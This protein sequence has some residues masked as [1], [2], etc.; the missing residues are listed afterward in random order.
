MFHSKS[1]TLL[2]LPITRITHRALRA[3]LRAIC[4][5]CLPGRLDSIATLSRRCWVG[6][7]FFLGPAGARVGVHLIPSYGSS[8]GSNSHPKRY[9]T[10][11]FRGNRMSTA[12]YMVCIRPLCFAF[13]PVQPALLGFCCCTSIHPSSNGLSLTSRPPVPAAHPPHTG[14]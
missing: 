11:L 2:R 10:I 12:V 6:P 4:G 7:S 14:G 8:Y 3:C 9:E 13:P 1:K 5:A